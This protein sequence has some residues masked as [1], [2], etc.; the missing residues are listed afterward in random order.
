MKKERKWTLIWRWSFFAILLVTLFW[1]I[2]FLIAHRLPIFSQIKIDHFSLNKNFVLSFSISRWWDIPASIIWPISYI[3]IFGYSPIYEEFKKHNS[4]NTFL[5]WTNILSGVFIGLCLLIIFISSGYLIPL[6]IA[7]FLILLVSIIFEGIYYPDSIY[8]IS[9]ED[10]SLNIL[11][12]LSIGLSI[13]L[14]ASFA[15]GLV[16]GIII[17][18]I[19][20]VVITLTQFVIVKF[21]RLIWFLL[22][23]LFEWL[24]GVSSY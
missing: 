8:E 23:K 9:K 19:S 13:G 17:T 12:N 10:F 24:T 14:G 18:L 21:F 6:F 7:F 1:I 5:I 15:S 20:F 11:Y 3:L 22:S 16:V 4:D 2:W